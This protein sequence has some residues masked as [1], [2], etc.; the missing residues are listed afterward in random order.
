MVLLCLEVVEAAVLEG[1]CAVYVMTT[2]VALLVPAATLAPAQSDQM[3][4]L[5]AVWGIAAL[6][7]LVGFLLSAVAYSF[8]FHRCMH[9]IWAVRDPHAEMPAG[10]VWAWHFVPIAFLIKPYDGAA[11]IWRGS[12]GAT[13]RDETIPA[14]FSVWW[15]GWLIGILGNQIKNMVMFDAYAEAVSLADYREFAVSFALEGVFIAMLL[16]SAGA[17]FLMTRRLAEAQ[18][19]VGIASAASTFS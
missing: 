11:Q 7:Y 13:G 2:I 15:A 18:K 4:P 6:G 14:L 8:F 19:E 5:E 9:N 3:A 17:L 1:F 12:M 10:M 16:V